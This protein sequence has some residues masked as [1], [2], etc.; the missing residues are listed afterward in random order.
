VNPRRDGV[1]DDRRPWGSV[2]PVV[3]ITRLAPTCPGPAMTVATAT[4]VSVAFDSWP[5]IG[6][7]RS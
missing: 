5:R 3:Q 6:C 2:S 7:E 1:P 4:G